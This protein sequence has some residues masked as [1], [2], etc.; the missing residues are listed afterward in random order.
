MEEKKITLK[1]LDAYIGIAAFYIAKDHQLDDEDASTLAMIA[2]D[3]R[4]YIF[5]HVTGKDPFDQGDLDEFYQIHER[6]DFLKKV[7]GN[8]IVS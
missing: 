3:I 7:M 8:I 4:N 6:V 2:G 5:G 1:E